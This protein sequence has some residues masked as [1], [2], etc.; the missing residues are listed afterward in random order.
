MKNFIIEQYFKFKTC[1][2]EFCKELAI[3]TGKAISGLKDFFISLDEWYSE[4]EEEIQEIT[5]ILFAL[6]IVFVFRV[7]ILH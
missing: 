3:V 7:I 5:S 2:D 4:A 1:L 6:L